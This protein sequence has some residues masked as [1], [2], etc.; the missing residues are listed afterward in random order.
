MLCTRAVGLLKEDERVKT[1][2]TLHVGDARNLKQVRDASVALVVTSPPYPMIA[3]WDGCF[4]AMDASITAEAIEQRPWQA[5]DAMHAQLDTVWR[6]CH[7]VLLP[8]GFACINIGDATRSTASGGF[9]LFP[10]HARIITSML[11]L[12]FTSLPD[13]LWRKPSNAPNKFMGSG[14]LPAGAYVTYEHEYV[15]VFRKGH[16]RDFDE[17]EDK[18]RR[19]ASAFFWEERNLWFSDLWQSITGIRQSGDFAL[20]RE[21][22]AAFPLEIPYRLI[23]MYSVQG[24]LVLDPFAG[25][26]TTA[27]AAAACARSSVGFEIEA[28][29]ADG[30]P[31]M[32]QASLPELNARNRL[33]FEQHVQFVAKRKEEGKLLKHR[34]EVL[35]CEVMTSQERQL[36]IWYLADCSV[37]DG[38]VVARHEPMAPA[39]DFRLE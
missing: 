38:Q 19:Q 9:A 8:G 13:I 24:D 28:T 35:D 30:F 3:M 18:Q 26:N 22:S 32:M 6:E 11:A 4:A 10:N 20:R 17:A 33:R 5:F 12:G 39:A 25:T 36:T 2:H 1:T 29:A 21:R 31:K 16:K 23:N 7:R 27:M 34:N 37:R 15:L 14:M